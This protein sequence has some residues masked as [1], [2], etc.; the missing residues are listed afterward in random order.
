M[1][2]VAAAA[3]LGS[4]SILDQEP[5]VICSETYYQSE[6][7]LLYGLAGVYGALTSEALYGRAYSLPISNTDDL[8]YQNRV[9]NVPSVHWYTHNA[10]DTD[11]MAAWQMLYAGIKNANEYMTA[12]A[13][14]EF[15]PEGRFYAEARFLRAYYHF[16]LAQAWGDVPLREKPTLSPTPEEVNIAATPQAEVLSW[17]VKE[18]EEALPLLPEVLDNAPSRV[19][20]TTA[21]G[22]LARIYLFMAGETV[23]LPNKEDL[24]AKAADW[25]GMVINSG[26]HQLNE[27]GYDKVFIHMICDTYDKTWNESMW[28]ADFLGTRTSADKWSNGRIGDLIGLQSTG[29]ENFLEWSC[30]YSYAQYN[31]SLKLW[32]LY[33]TEDRTEEEKSLPTITDKRQEWNLPT[34][35]YK[36]GTVDGVK[37]TISIDKTPY[38]YNKVSTFTDPTVAVGIR[39]CGKWRR[40]TCY[41]APQAGK[42]LYTGINFPI[43]R[44]SDVLL[45][46]AEAKNEAEGPSEELYNCVKQVRDRA[47]IQT[48]PYADY[49]SQEALRQLIRNERGRELCF[50]ALRKYDLIRWGIFVEAMHGYNE[51]TTDSRWES[52]NT[53][54]QYAVQT[55]NSVQEKHIYLPIPLKELGVNTSLKQNPMW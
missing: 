50:E 23:K 55:A 6:S 20:Q 53:L 29:S 10:S 24:F 7:E 18:I 49:S 52:S 38:I 11:V 15:D 5:Q 41:E 30:N 2:T 48:R 19:V 34:Y 25:A 26:K 4:C 33:W 21:A 16:L 32:D 35:N 36:G 28:E 40:E 37:Y 39:N 45:M 46:Y 47:G 51:M 13:D 22:I 8:S 9:H 44:Y 27:D 54:A 31:G 1:L 43:L 12:I 17:C 42:N 14:S 3:T